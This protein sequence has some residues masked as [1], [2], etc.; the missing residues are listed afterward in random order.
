MLNIGENPIKDIN[1]NLSFLSSGSKVVE[2]TPPETNMGK[3][4][5]SFLRTGSKVVEYT[6]QPS[7]WVSGGKFGKSTFS[8]TV[9]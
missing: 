5:T 2:C 7:G 8:C 6:H 3:F 4:L 9:Q 1:V